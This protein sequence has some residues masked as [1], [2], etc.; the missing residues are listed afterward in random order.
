MILPIE[1]SIT[2]L[3]IDLYFLTRRTT[4]FTFITCM[5]FILSTIN[6]PFMITETFQRIL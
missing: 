2:K 3:V 6:L 4:F 5:M 1:P